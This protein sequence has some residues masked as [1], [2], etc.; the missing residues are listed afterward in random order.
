MLYKEHPYT[1]E[2]WFQLGKVGKDGGE[3]LSVQSALDLRGLLR[4]ASQRE[5]Q[6][7]WEAELYPSCSSLQFLLLRHQLSERPPNHACNPFK[8]F[9]LCDLQGNGRCIP[10]WKPGA[11]LA[12]QCQWQAAPDRSSTYPRWQAVSVPGLGSLFSDLGALDSVASFAVP[13]SPGSVSGFV[14]LFV[15]SL[16]SWK[17]VTHSA[18]PSRGLLP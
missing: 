16:A 3:Y 12:R 8:W 5:V 14:C 11:H 17:V 10:M 18:I 2:Y 9:H 6:T 7:L 15:F 13:E 1:R 4:G